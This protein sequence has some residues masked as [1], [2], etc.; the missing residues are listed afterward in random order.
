[1]TT[2]LTIVNRENH[3][4]T[5][6]AALKALAAMRIEL[7][8]A[9][10]YADI[11]KAIDT[12]KAIKLLWSDVEVVKVEAEDTIL[13]ATVRIGEELK[14]IPKAS[15]GNSNL[16]RLGDLGREATGLPSTMRSRHMA[17]AE[18]KADIAAASE[19]LRAQGKDATP[20]AVVRELTQGDKKQRRATR[21]RDLG[22][23]QRQLP[24]DQRYGV[25]YADPPWSFTPYSTETGMDRAADNHY[26]TM[27]VEAIAALPVPAAED[28]VLF[29]WAT[30]PMLPE[31]L[32]VM[33]AWGFAYKSHFVW[34]KDKVGT[35]YWSRNRHELLLIGTRG[36][37]PAPAPGDQYE[38]VISAARGEHSAKPFAFREM[39]DDLFPTLPRIELFARG[40][41][42]VGWDAWGNEAG[43]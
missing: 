15:G 38:S 27:T 40:E 4:Q 42:Y 19:R 22:Q 33:A 36:S 3:L 24:A 31:A 32:A 9:K 28:A 6:P 13:A 2:D 11:H 7:E 35:G 41:S 8:S 21:E 30:V 29:L 16:P 5:V 1:M 10:T 25:I 12:A 34:V 43:G 26:P 37:V 18:H 23:R 20:N 39:I 17:L 14:R